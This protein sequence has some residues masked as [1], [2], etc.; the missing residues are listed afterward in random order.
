VISELFSLRNKKK[1]NVLEREA[2]LHQARLTVY[3]MRAPSAIF[4][5]N[6][7]K[8][9]SNTQNGERINLPTVVRII[10]PIV[11]SVC[12]VQYK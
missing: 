8:V 2:Y 4:S 10:S 6:V 3:V 12:N 9:I 1:F 5:L 7:G 11:L